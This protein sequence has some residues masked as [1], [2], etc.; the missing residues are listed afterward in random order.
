MIDRGDFL[1]LTNKDLPVKK[2]GEKRP[3]QRVRKVALNNKNGKSI[4]ERPKEANERAEQ[5]HWE[6]DREK[7]SDSDVC[8]SANAQVAVCACEEYSNLIYCTEL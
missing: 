8:G 2:D 3:Y 6:I 4:D 7:T 1:N 5:G